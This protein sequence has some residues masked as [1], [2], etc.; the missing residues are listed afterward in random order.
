MTEQSSAFAQAALAD[1]QAGSGTEYIRELG[2]TVRY[3]LASA[4]AVRRAV[5]KAPKG[6]D[7]K[8]SAILVRDH[9]TLE[10]GTPIVTRDDAGLQFLLDHV[11][12]DIIGRLGKLVAG[13]SAED[14]GND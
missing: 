1:F 12:P 9:V 8:A 2:L 7:I 6:D 13:R 5:A 3:S 4:G 14:L 11:R 10:D